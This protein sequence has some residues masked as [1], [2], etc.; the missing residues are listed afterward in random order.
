VTSNYRHGLAEALVQ[1]W[2]RLG[3]P[4]HAKSMAAE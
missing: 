1:V 2:E 3:L 4:L